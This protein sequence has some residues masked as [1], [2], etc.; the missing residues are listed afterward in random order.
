VVGVVAYL[1][2]RQ[3]DEAN[4]A[5]KAKTEEAQK[6]NDQARKDRDDAVKLRD[7][8][9][10]TPTDTIDAIG[11]AKDDEMTNVYASV[12]GQSYPQSDRVYRKVIRTFYDTVKN[13][14]KQ[15]LDEQELRKKAETDVTNLRAELAAKVKA[16]EDNTAT[17]QRDLKNRTDEFS[18]A[19]KDLL[20][21]RDEEAGK[22]K[23]AIDDAN[24]KMAD[25]QNTIAAGNS[26]IDRYKRWVEDLKRQLEADRKQT[27][28]EALG[29]IISANQAS[30]TVYINLGQADALNRLTTFSVYDA[31]T[32]DVSRGGKKGTIE[33]TQLSSSAP[34]M[35]EARIVDAKLGDPILAGD[36]IY[37]PIWRPGQQRHFALAGL[38]DMDGDGKSDLEL[39]RR[40]IT[41]N[42]GVVDSFREGNRR[43]GTL[44]E[45][46]DYLVIGMI[47]DEKS[48][49]AERTDFTNVVTVAERLLVKKIDLKDLL[50]QMGWKPDTNLQKYGPGYRPQDFVP[51]APP[52][53]QRV[54]TGN[55]SP[56]FKP[57]EPRGNA[58]STY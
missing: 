48:L 17:V 25:L 56:L 24:V 32:T 45:R 51:K 21:Q 57:R 43:I 49:P 52:G 29:R 50:A 27:F 31:N 44:G 38:I 39:I 34:H 3:Y 9:G 33:V 13:R 1:M 53:S 16:E 11:K 28:E 46:T 15:I 5:A 20:A 8:M 30:R 40:L 54:S 36:V 14:D 47:P 4:I 37:T 23:V 35:A 42:G 2:W 19:H 12:F 26:E 6:A 55:V 22:R 58:P 18:Q 10:F 7:W 41:M